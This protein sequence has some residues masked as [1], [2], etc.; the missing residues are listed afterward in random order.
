M[1]ALDSTTLL[2]A[3]LAFALAP[4]GCI[5]NHDVYAER[6]QASGGTSATGAGGRTVAL[7][8]GGAGGFGGHADRDA[9]VAADAQAAPDD[10]PGPWRLTLLHG[11]IDSPW[12]GFCFAPVR[13]GKEQAVVGVPVPRTGLEYG[14]SFTA[15]SL[16][17]VD[18]GVEGLRAYVVAAASAAAVAGLDC[19][20]I[21]AR[22]RAL[23]AAP[24][25]LDAGGPS[26]LP[27]A[28]SPRADAGMRDAS[29]SSP[30]A[31]RQTDASPGSSD[32]A[33]SQGIDASHAD[34]R[35]PPAPGTVPR[36]IASVRVAA[37]PIVPAGSLS[38]SRSYLL[39][40]GGCIGG[41]GVTDPSER[42]VCGE[43]YSAVAPTV[44]EIVVQLPRKVSPGR[45]GLSFLGG[46]PALTMSDLVL[47]PGPHTDPLKIARKVVTGALRPVP[48]NTDSSVVDIGAPS[49]DAAIE[50]Y[51]SGAP[52]AAY[53]AP[54]KKTFDAGGFAALE[55]GKQYTLV[56]IGPYP[57]FSA[58]SWW[59]DPLVTI[60]R[61]DP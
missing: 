2:V 33:A 1:R 43:Y 60:V 38:A 5:S 28:R 36:G 48:P 58:R 53:S 35:S 29:V 18:L 54:W 8:S 26:S 3:S 27:D 49:P 56:A 16:V 21:L 25:V 37:L 59:N 50:L 11:V 31:S 34:A 23:G 13:A 41:P 32:A 9:A 44:T 40:A 46:T 20:A 30:D 61:N 39:V 6:G 7:P 10:P 47:Q 22:A 15:G 45:V 14:H 51:P 17:G 55:D 24:P 12:V 57:G 19:A 52:T 42:S 4:G